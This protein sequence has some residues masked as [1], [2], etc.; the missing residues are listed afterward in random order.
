MGIALKCTFTLVTL[1]RVTAVAI[2]NRDHTFQ[3]DVSVRVYF[4]W[5]LYPHSDSQICYTFVL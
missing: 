1:E 3:R 4:P 5:K 2:P